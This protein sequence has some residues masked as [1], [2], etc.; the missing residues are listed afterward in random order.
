MAAPSAPAGVQTGSAAVAAES[1]WAGQGIVALTNAW[2]PMAAGTGFAFRGLMADLPHAIVLAPTAAAATFPGG[3]HILPILRFSGR[4]GGPLKV[5]SLLQHLEVILAPIAWCAMPG[6]PRPAV[7]VCVQPL[8]CGVGGLLAKRVL[9]IPFVVLLHGEELALFR[10]S[11]SRFDIRAR[12]LRATLRAASALICNSQNTRRLALEAYGVPEEKLHVI[13]PSVNVEGR[14]TPSPEE[15]SALRRGLVGEGRMVL[16]VGRLAET[17]KGFDT[18]IAAMPAVLREVPDCVL[19]IAGPGDQRRLRGL[20]KDGGVGERVRLL[21]QVGPSELDTL[22]SACDLFL[23]PGRE[24]ETTAE[25]F[26]I[27]FLEA[28]LA[29]KP[30]IGGRAGGVPEAVADG[31]TGILVDGT[32]S[33][34]VAEAVVRL[35]RDSEYAHRLGMQGRRR[36]QQEF[37]G[38]RQ[39]QRFAEVVGGARRA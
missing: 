38:R 24:I 30:V 12:L 19:V 28:A 35:L 14:R 26:G 36:V 25:G 8:F 33:A 37:D 39:R 29:G 34:A 2:P 22:Y 18:A 20:A 15:A 11:T 1:P 5:F 16:M 9:G 21:G 3:P 4:A 31:Q 17:H 6:R 27:V 10:H 7:L 23:L 32:S 13:H